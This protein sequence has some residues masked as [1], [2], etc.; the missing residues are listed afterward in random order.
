MLPPIQPP[1]HSDPPFTKTGT[2]ASI[3]TIICLIVLAF[4][5]YECHRHN[6]TM[7]EAEKEWWKTHTT[8]PQA[9]LDRTDIQRW[10]PVLECRMESTEAHPT[11]ISVCKTV[12]VDDTITPELLK[13]MGLID[14][15]DRPGIF[16]SIDR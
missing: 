13:E 5:M 12:Y 7:S 11:P 4:L 1:D 2:F 9:L 3:M 15:R 14:P 8:T 6:F 10:R 16:E